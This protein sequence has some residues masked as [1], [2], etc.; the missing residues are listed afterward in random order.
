MHKH[1]APWTLVLTI[2]F[3]HSEAVGSANCPN[4]EMDESTKLAYSTLLYSNVVAFKKVVQTAADASKCIKGGPML[5][6]AIAARKPE[7]LA[8]ILSLGD[9]TE[10][11][12]IPDEQ[13]LVAAVEHRFLEGLKLL[14]ESGAQINK[15]YGKGYGK[16]LTLLQAIIEEDEAIVEYLISQGVDINGRTHLGDTAL[17]YA[18]RVKKEAMVRLLMRL[19]ASTAVE[20]REGRSAEDYAS[21]L[22]VSDW[23]TSP[24]TPAP[25]VKVE[26][27]KPTRKQ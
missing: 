2:F 18:L 27:P 14:V 23:L 22:G 25:P 9:R 4:S 12:G 19:G 11:S 15:D 10:L 26:Q 16:I 7:H 3:G 1:A 13:L 6:W 20:T 17:H 8:H 5:Y 21:E 24:V